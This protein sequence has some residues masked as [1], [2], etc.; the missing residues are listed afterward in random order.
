V[1]A[2]RCGDTTAGICVLASEWNGMSGEP[3]LKPEGLCRPSS[4]ACT[5]FFFLSS[6]RVCGCFSV[7]LVVFRLSPPVAGY[8]RPKYTGLGVRWGRTAHGQSLIKSRPH[9][10]SGYLFH[11]HWPAQEPDVVRLFI[12]ESL[13]TAPTDGQR[14]CWER[15]ARLIVGVPHCNCFRTVYQVSGNPTYNQYTSSATYDSAGRSPNVTCIRPED[16]LV[17]KR[18]RSGWPHCRTTA[19]GKNRNGSTT[20]VDACWSHKRTRQRQK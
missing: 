15:D 10:R 5:I 18:G 2:E 1:E 8:K 9:V 16:T 13:H 14:T 11:L 17:Q 12:C 19:A 3:T 7:R 20:V 6:Y 4:C